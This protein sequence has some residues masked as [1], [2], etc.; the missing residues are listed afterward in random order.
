MA[1]DA[2]TCPVCLDVVAGVRV[3]SCGHIYCGT[4]YY[5]MTSRSSAPSCAVCRATLLPLAYPSFDID[6]ALE[7]SG[8]EGH[9]ERVRLSRLRTKELESR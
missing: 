1:T 2:F 5:D 4:C 3:A 7:G 9:K 6:A 8:G